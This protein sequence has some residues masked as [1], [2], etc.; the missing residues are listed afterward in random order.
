MYSNAFDFFLY[1]ARVLGYALLKTDFSNILVEFLTQ[2]SAP[3]VPLL[4]L[5]LGELWGTGN[6]LGEPNVGTRW[7][8]EPILV[9]YEQNSYLKFNSRGLLYSAY[10]KLPIISEYRFIED[11]SSVKM[12]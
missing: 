3:A 2:G 11:F 8:P 9:K 6:R 12:R 10:K 4:F 5:K 7:N 1:K